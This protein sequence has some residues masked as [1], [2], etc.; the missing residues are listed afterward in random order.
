MMF[1]AE[2]ALSLI[3]SVLQL[4][5]CNTCDDTCVESCVTLICIGTFWQLVLHRTGRYSYFSDIS[6]YTVH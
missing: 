4:L 1:C 6:Y 2:R 5:F 3:V